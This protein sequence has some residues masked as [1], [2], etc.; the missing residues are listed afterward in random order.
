MAASV[1]DGERRPGKALGRGDEHVCGVACEAL[2]PSESRRTGPG[3]RRP[4]VV[5]G[6]RGDQGEELLSCVRVCVCVVWWWRLSETRGE[7][8]IDL[9][10]TTAAMGIG[11]R[12]SSPVCVCVCC[13][14]AAG[15]RDEGRGGDRAGK[16]G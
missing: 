13:V 2:E 1:R 5:V 16:V 7:V 12:S 10:F 9:G 8:G 15:E 14:V 6:G 4:E 11:A 3:A